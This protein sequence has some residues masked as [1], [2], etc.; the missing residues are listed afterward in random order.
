MDTVHSDIRSAWQIN[1]R[2]T[3]FL[4]EHL[5]DAVWTAPVPG[6]S[7]RT[8]QHIAAHL[9]NNRC[10]WIKAM[11]DKL[12][13]AAPQRVDSQRVSCQQPIA[14]LNDS[15]LAILAMIDAAVE[16]YG[17]M[18]RG[19]WQN[20]PAEVIHFLVYHAAHEESSPRTDGYAGASTRLPASA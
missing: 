14:A 15:S 2:V 16:R 5:P 6:T 4:L 20:F 19:A 13:I 10:S 17:R 8:V 12:G 1:N 9:H 7:R 3:T 18:P 11:G